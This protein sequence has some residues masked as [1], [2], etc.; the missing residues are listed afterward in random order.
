MMLIL[1]S[2]TVVTDKLSNVLANQSQ[3]ATLVKSASFGGKKFS[4]R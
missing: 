1:K 2:F 3:I 4:F